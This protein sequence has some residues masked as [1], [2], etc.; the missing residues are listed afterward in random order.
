MSV[1]EFRSLGV[2]SK[3]IIEEARTFVASILPPTPL[4][5]CEIHGLRLWLKL[6]SLQPTGAFKVRGA[7]AAIHHVAE[8]EPGRR[9]VTCSA[10]NHGL[11][12]AWA[13]SRL[14]VAATVVVPRTAS[15]AKISKLKDFSIDLRLLGES[16]DEAEEAALEFAQEQG[17][18]FI[19]PYNDTYVI[20]GQA[21]LA[22][23]VTE[24]LPHAAHLV[25]AVGGGGLASGAALALEGHACQLH[26]AQIQQNAAFSEIFEG[27]DV[28]FGRLEPTIADGIAGGFEIDAVTLSILH[29]HPFDLTLV[30][31]AATKEAM[32]RAS[33]DAGIVM[34]GSAGVAL[35]AAFQRADAWDGEIVVAVTGQNI[36]QSEFREVLNAYAL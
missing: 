14:G 26:G 17:A 8:N 6:E 24:Q 23:E 31:E 29:A 34:E 18:R 33:A 15:P 9:V 25:V 16:Y 12:I 32:A 4:V 7:L 36:S 21:T 35:A 5:E 27:R 13:A 22:H 28:D 11:G 19:S 1:Q 3:E 2:P 20:A 10:G 30:S